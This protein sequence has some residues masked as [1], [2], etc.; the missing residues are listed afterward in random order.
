MDALVFCI[1]VFFAKSILCFSKSLD[2]DPKTEIPLPRDLTIQSSDD[3]D[4]SE[5]KKLT[6][7]RQRH[8]KT[9]DGALCAAAFV[10]NGNTFTDCTTMEAP[11]GSVGREWCYLEVQLIGTGARDWDFC[12]GVVDYDLLR[13]KAKSLMSLRALELQQAYRSLVREERRL[14]NTMSKYEEVCG[15]GEQDYE[16]DISRLET[17]LLGVERAIE[18]LRANNSSLSSLIESRDSLEDEVSVLS[19]SALNNRKNCSIVRGYDDHEGRADGLRATYYDNAYFR[20]TPSGFLDHPNVNFIW[21]DFVPVSG[22]PHDSFS[23]RVEGYLRVP[24]TDVYTFYVRSDCNVRVFMDEEVI[25]SQGFDV[26]KD[27]ILGPVNPLPLDGR[28]TMNVFLKSNPFHLI[29]GKRYPI[30]IEYSHQK[31]LKYFNSDVAKVILSWSSMSIPEQLIPPEYFFKGSGQN[32]YI[33]ISGLE[34]EHY[35]LSILENG[36]QAFKGASNFVIADVPGRFAGARMIR[37]PTKPAEQLVSFEVSNDAVVFVAIPTVSHTLP[38]DENDVPFEKNSDLLSVYGIGDNC[39]VAQTQIEM[40]IYSMKF[41][42]GNVKLLLP[43]DTS[44]IIFVV[45]SATSGICKGDV[46]IL[47]FGPNDKCIASSSKNEYSGCNQGFG[48]GMVSEDSGWITAKDKTEGEFLRRDFESMVELR[49]FHF[50]PKGSL[51]ASVVTFNFSDGTS[52]EFALTDDLRYEFRAFRIVNWVRIEINRVEMLEGTDNTTGGLFTLFG[53]VCQGMKPVSENVQEVDISFC[54]D[55]CD[56][57]NSLVVDSGHTKSTHQ[58]LYFGWETQAKP[59]RCNHTHLEKEK[60]G[61]KAEALPPSEKIKESE[62]EDEINPN[63]PMIKDGFLL[64]G[65]KWSL[66][67]PFHGTFRIRVK[68]GAKCRDLTE[69]SLTINGYEVFGVENLHKGVT[70]TYYGTISLENVGKIELGSKTEDPDFKGI[71]FRNY[72]PRDENLKK[73]CKTFLDDYSSIENTID[74]QI[75]QTIRNYESEDVLSLV[76]PRRQNWDLKRELNRKKQ[77]LSNRTDSAILRLLH[78]TKSNNQILAHQ[79]AQMDSDDSEDMDI[80]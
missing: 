63:Y 4:Q 18:Q 51:K 17:S 62:Q 40:S 70:A 78:E 80:E 73:L 56:L 44:S 34:G 66:D 5:L 48:N 30:T 22:V 65:N 15:S 16:S 42:R 47:S 72:I 50:V 1:F 27:G 38:K 75:D 49:Y 54:T 69:I 24:S 29:G 77:I 46:S 20:G 6:E 64:K 21:E 59:D 37:M 43:K 33:A 57:A 74:E 36:A 61:P 58:G 31:V 79:V 32:S 39:R 28:S 45:P 52:E 35:T 55:N 12:V 67:A 41:S 23:V 19:K 76:R 2:I 71:V 11:D 68:V 3:Y 14:D 53:I 10:R 13:E 25:M 7:F 8:R 60:D 26:N 9:L